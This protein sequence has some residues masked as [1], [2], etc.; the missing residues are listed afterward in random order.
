MPRCGGPTECLRRWLILCCKTRQWLA[1]GSRNRRLRLRGTLYL[2]IDEGCVALKGETLH[3]IVV[4][5]DGVGRGS[6]PD[7]RVLAIVDPM[8]PQRGD[9]DAAGELE[10]L[11]A[12]L[13]GFLVRS[14]SR[15]RQHE[16][17][18]SGCIRF[19][20]RRPHAVLRL[21]TKK[22]R[23]RPSRPARRSFVED[24]PG[25]AQPEPPS[26]HPRRPLPARPAHRRGDRAQG[27]R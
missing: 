16:R 23:N 20:S 7:R 26:P 1:I 15:R 27:G 18:Q 12:P 24:I 8:S 13:T 2:G 4:A 25:E 22:R 10:G 5:G 14:I 11:F 3:D 9:C 19:G 6:L 21:R 17:S